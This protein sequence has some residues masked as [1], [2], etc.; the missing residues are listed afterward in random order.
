[1]AGKFV[2]SNAANSQYRFVLKAGNAETILTSELY[3]SKAG[4]QNGIASVKENAPHDDHPAVQPHRR[5]GR[6]HR[7][8]RD[9]TAAGT[10]AFL[11]GGISHWRHKDNWCVKDSSSLQPRSPLRGPLAFCSSFCLSTTQRALRRSRSGKNG[12]NLGT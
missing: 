10:S 12:N 7:R 2:L 11:L 8:R 1:M 3:A 6:T 9:A 4:A 5:S